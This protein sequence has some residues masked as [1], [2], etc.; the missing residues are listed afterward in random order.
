[1]TCFQTSQDPRRRYKWNVSSSC[2]RE[3]NVVFVTIMSEIKL[4][5]H[6]SETAASKYHTISRLRHHLQNKSKTVTSIWS[7]VF[8][9]VYPFQSKQALTPKYMI[10]HKNRFNHML[11]FLIAV[12]SECVKRPGAAELL[13]WHNLPWKTF[14]HETHETLTARRPLRGDRAYVTSIKNVKYEV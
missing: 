8:I 2:Q 1:M 9:P 14:Y 12:L 13:A 10:R 5:A 4:S 3:H 11:H 7:K 6:A